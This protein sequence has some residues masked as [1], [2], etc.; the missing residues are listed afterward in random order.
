[1]ARKGVVFITINYRV[2]IFGFFAHPW[3]TKESPN[4]SSGNY[5]LLDQIEALKWIKK[6]IA[7]FGGNPNNITIAGQSAGAFSVN[8]LVASPIAKG[9]FQKAI[10]ESGG[11]ILPTNLAGNIALEQAEQAGK[12]YS[13][14]LNAKSIAELRDVPAEDL[15]KTPGTFIPG[16]DGYVLPHGVYAI[17]SEGKQN[18]VPLITGWNADE[19]NFSGPPLNAEKFKQKA[20]ETYGDKA[21]KFLKLFPSNTDEEAKQSQTELSQLTTFGLQAYAWMKIQDETG[22]SPVFMYHFARILPYGEGQQPFGAFHTGEVPYAYNNLHMSN[23]PWKNIDHE[24]ANI[25]SSYWANFAATGNPNGNGLPEWLPCSSDNLRTIFLDKDIDLNEI[26][27]KKRLKF[28]EK[29]YQ[30]TILTNPIYNGTAN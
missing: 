26:P 7:N 29:F 1:M 24:L 27:Q 21:E 11:A 25:M 2:G 16:I 8:F 4:H 5:G 17:F 28:L 22:E 14:K 18:D 10:A 13:E 19:G 30:Q 20:K 9:L 23:R 12:Q 6:N 15:L 3:L